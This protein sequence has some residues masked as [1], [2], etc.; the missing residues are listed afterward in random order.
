MLGAFTGA[1]REE[2]A[3]LAPA[4]IVEI[5]GIEC[6]NIEDSELR[7][8][9]NISS[10]RIVPIHTR[11]IK[12]GFLELVEKARAEGRVDLFP[13]LREPASGM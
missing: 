12:I 4:D 2:I 11:L 5:D 7:R 1:R 8:I 13:D 10:N 6:L 9:K 3:G